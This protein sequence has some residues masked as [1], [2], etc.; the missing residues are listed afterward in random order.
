VW[1][2]RTVR[3]NRIVTSRHGV[4]K[5]SILGSLLFLLYI[6]DLSK[7]ISDKSN[8]V[9]FVDDTSIIITNSYPLAFRNNI[10]EVFREINEWFQGTQLSLNYDK[11]YFLQFVIKTNKSIPK[12]LL[13]TNPTPIHSTKFLGLTV[14]SS[15]SWKY[16]IEELKSKLNKACYAIKSFKPFMSLEV[17]KMTYFL[18]F[19]QFCHVV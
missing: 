6:N 2:S 3:C 16:H 14:D 9:L 17:L 10:N 5:G 8:P 18:M 19:I 13:E 7:I 15:L 11:T 12:Y 4:P 1:A